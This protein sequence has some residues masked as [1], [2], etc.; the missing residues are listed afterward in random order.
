MCMIFYNSNAFPFSMTPDSH[1][2][3]SERFVVGSANDRVSRDHLNSSSI[4]SYVLLWYGQ[5]ELGDQLNFTKEEKLLRLCINLKEKC[6][7]RGLRI[8]I[9]SPEYGK[10]TFFSIEIQGF[11]E[12]R[13]NDDCS[14]G[15]PFFIRT[16]IHWA[17]ENTQL[18]PS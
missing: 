16:R 9:L 1:L 8:I 4:V 6:I 14:L 2:K 10:Y 7:F 17:T 13:S 15:I 18:R 3:Q 5:S 12:L 11:Q